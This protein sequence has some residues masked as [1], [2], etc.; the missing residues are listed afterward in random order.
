MIVAIAILALVSVTL[1]ETFSIGLR[2]VRSVSEREIA[3]LHAKSKLAES[4]DT[5]PL[6]EATDSGEFDNGMQWEVRVHSLILP[7][8]EDFT[9]P[10]AE[11]FEVFV[12]VRGKGEQEVKLR[13]IRSQFIERY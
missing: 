3:L 10:L 4:A 2:S 1:F 12:T 13:T 11:I 7:E 5:W 8:Q 9:E 6:K